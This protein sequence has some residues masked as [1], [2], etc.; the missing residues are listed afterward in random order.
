VTP[1]IDARLKA[2]WSSDAIEL[3]RRLEST[4]AGLSSAD[5][6]ARLRRCGP[7]VLDAGPQLSRLRV[8]QNQLRSPLLLLLI[9]AAGASIVTGEWFDAAIV[10]AIV[11]ATAGIGY[12]REYGAQ[13]SAEALR[14]RIRMRAK[15][16]RDGAVTTIETRQITLGYVAA[17]ELVKR[18]FYGPNESRPRP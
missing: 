18:L 16:L 13:A 5:A 12:S 14:V 4:P 3:G 11:V 2:Y 17:T 9:F 1:A 7:N 6:D 15:V 10:L 8:L